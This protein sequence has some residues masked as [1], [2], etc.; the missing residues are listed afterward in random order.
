[1]SFQNVTKSQTVSR[2]SFDCQVACVSDFIVWFL[3]LLSASETFLRARISLVS[4]SEF[5]CNITIRKQMSYWRLSKPPKPNKNVLKSLTY[6]VFMIVT[7][8]AFISIQT[9]RQT[10]S[11]SLQTLC[12]ADANALQ[13]LC[14]LF[15]NALQTPFKLFR[16]PFKMLSNVIQTPSKPFQTLSNPFKNISNFFQTLCKRF[17]NPSQTPFGPNCNVR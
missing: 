2:K 9:L 1:M 15:P 7:K 17:A 6:R 4:H 13:T 12:E 8:V 14:K 10:I 3:S 16:N 5:L 11:N